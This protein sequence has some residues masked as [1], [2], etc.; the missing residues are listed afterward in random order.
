MQQLGSKMSVAGM[1]P[2]EI[3]THLEI[4]IWLGIQW[5]GGRGSSSWGPGTGPQL[6]TCPAW[7]RRQEGGRSGAGQRSVCDMEQKKFIHFISSPTMIYSDLSMLS[8]LGPIKVGRNTEYPGYF[9]V[10][11]TRKTY[12]TE[13]FG[14]CNILSLITDHMESEHVWVWVS[15][16]YWLD[17]EKNL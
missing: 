8:W 13:S 3:Q 2:P 12:T 6:W 5:A 17:L 11:H 14:R 15:N 10:G 7:G 4:W 16:S 1:W 9:L